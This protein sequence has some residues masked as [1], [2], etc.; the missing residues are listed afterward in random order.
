M[1]GEEAGPGRG[2]RLRRMLR[3]KIHRVR[4]TGAELHYSGSLSL[5]SQLMKAAGLLAYEQVDVVNINNGARFSTYLIEGGPGECCLNGAAARL[6]VTGDLLIVM[7]FDLLE[8]AV[9]LHHEPVI[10]HV[11]EENRPLRPS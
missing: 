2:M 9:A 3:A 1:A 11:D 8:E 6:G 7:A 4:V 10:V 5:D